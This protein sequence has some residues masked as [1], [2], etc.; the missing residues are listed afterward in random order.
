MKERLDRHFSV[1]N[2]NINSADIKADAEFIAQFGQEAFD[3]HIAPKYKKGIMSI[4]DRNANFYH[5]CWV[6]LVTA[7]VNQN[8]GKRNARNA[9]NAAAGSTAKGTRAPD[10]R[11]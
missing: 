2:L 10:P 7:Y 4:F 6:T 3:K 1:F 9:K 5:H 8:R 11:D